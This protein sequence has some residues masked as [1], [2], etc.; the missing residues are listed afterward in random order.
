M[1]AKG[2]PKGSG[3]V[4]KIAMRSVLL[5]YEARSMSICQPRFWA[6]LA[7]L[8]LLLELWQG[9]RSMAV[10][11][12]SATIAASVRASRAA[13][14]RA[15]ASSRSDSPSDD[16]SEEASDE[17]HDPES[18]QEAD[19]E[20]EPEPDRE[21]EDDD[22]DPAKRS[23]QLVSVIA[24]STYGFLGQRSRKKIRYFVADKL[25]DLT[26]REAPE[27]PPRAA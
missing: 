21:A 14:E 25:S 26:H 6:L 7:V 3:A 4:E 19:D 10:W 17:D 22:E 12:D 1:R 27:R 2:K 18:A 5:V 23:S 16:E 15:G 8:S 9:G 20:S 13:S 24:H 11:S